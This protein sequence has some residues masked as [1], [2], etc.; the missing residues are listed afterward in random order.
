[1]SNTKTIMGQ[2]SNQ[3][4][5]PVVD[6]T[7][8]F[9][10]YLYDGTGAAQTINN[11]V[12]LAGKGGMVWVKSRTTAF[13]HMLADTE[14]GA[15]KYLS[16]NSTQRALGPNANALTSFNSNGFSIGSLN[17]YNPFPGPYTNFAI[18]SVYTEA[19]IG[20]YGNTIKQLFNRSG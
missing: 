20:L 13:E 18:P 5:T 6:I 10:T 9:S 3:Y 14:T 8:V 11:G 4:V 12:D 16:T 7:D 17:D 1:M 19:I 2:A 15:G